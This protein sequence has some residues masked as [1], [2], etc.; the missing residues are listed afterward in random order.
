MLFDPFRTEAGVLQ[1][2]RRTFAARR[3]HEHRVVAVVAACSPAPSTR[4][5]RSGQAA[6]GA[7]DGE[8]HTAVRTLEGVAALPAENGGRIAAPIEQDKRLIAARKPLTNRS[9]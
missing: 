2:R 5:A 7:V 6:A 9:R 3:R 4:V 1:V 8:R